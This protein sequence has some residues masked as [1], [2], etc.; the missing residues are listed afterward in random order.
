MD[1]RGR[2]HG[3]LLDGEEELI[4]ETLKEKLVLSTDK[5]YLAHWE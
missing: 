5:I 4:S 1:K 3:N 2:L